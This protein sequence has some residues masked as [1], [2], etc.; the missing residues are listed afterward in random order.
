MLITTG[1]LTVS[2]MTGYMNLDRTGSPT[3][4]TTLGGGKELR[5]VQFNPLLLGPAHYGGGGGTPI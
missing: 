2:G 1:I 3:R 4:A 5:E